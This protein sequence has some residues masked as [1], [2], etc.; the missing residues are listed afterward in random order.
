MTLKGVIAGKV[1]G[2]ILHIGKRFNVPN[3]IL[4]TANHIDRNIKPETH[5]LIHESITL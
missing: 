3:V 5:E 2:S 1:A 4:V